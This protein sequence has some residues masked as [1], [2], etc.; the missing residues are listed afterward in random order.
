MQSEKGT[1]A[2]MTVDV[3]SDLADAEQVRVEQLKEN[4]HFLRVYQSKFANFSTLRGKRQE[5][6]FKATALFRIVGDEAFTARPV[7]VSASAR[8]LHS[9][10]AFVVRATD[11]IFVWQG[12][13]ATDVALE[14]AVAF[15]N[16]IAAGRPV[17]RLLEGNESAVFWKAL[18]GKDTYY[19][20]PRTSAA[21]R[22]ARLFLL[23]GASGSIKVEECFQF[24]QSDLD[25]NHIALLDCFNRFYVWFG[26]NSPV[27]EKKM[28]MRVALVCASA[29]TDRNARL[30]VRSE[31]SF[32]GRRWWWWWWWWW[33]Y[34]GLH[35]RV[36]SR[37]RCQHSHSS[38]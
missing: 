3:S 6:D 14:K 20:V 24:T 12:V 18:N 13:Y 34:L 31:G 32:D 1:S 17:Q 29:L 19:Q 36:T 23:S 22:P 10:H 9:R 27:A 28:A 5:Y 25:N 30:A 35:S 21:L 16:A 2:Y 8:S 15:A 26:P 7:E 38:H 4:L 11:S 33:W 37:S